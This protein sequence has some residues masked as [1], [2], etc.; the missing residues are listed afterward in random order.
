GGKW[1][2]LP[3]AAQQLIFDRLDIYLHGHYTTSTDFNVN[4]VDAINEQGGGFHT[5]DDAA[6][7][8]LDEAKGE[9]R[10][11]VAGSSAL[12]GDQLATD[13]DDALEKWHSVATEL[14][15]EEFDDW[16]EAHSYIEEN[17]D[18]DPQ[19]LVDEV[20]SQLYSQHRP[21]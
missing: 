17:G 14:D 13:L 16:T 18:I 12:D 7:S 10:D 15:M 1:D 3:L 4:A 6:Q 19:E 8:A 9:L 20:S 11:Q 21:E 5:L 2:T